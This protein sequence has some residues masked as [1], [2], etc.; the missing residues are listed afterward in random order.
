M[1]VD[2]EY[3]Y[4]LYSPPP[5]LDMNYEH[6]FKTNIYY[7]YTKW[8]AIYN[9]WI[10]IHLIVKFVNKSNDIYSHRRNIMQINSPSNTS[11]QFFIMMLTSFWKVREHLHFVGNERLFI[12]NTWGHMNIYMAHN[13]A[14]RDQSHHMRRL[15]LN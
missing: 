13:T 1:H 12:K 6:Y 5:P 4:S 10:Q 15:E 14:R 11:T 8:M 7:V 2:S 9:M 3:L